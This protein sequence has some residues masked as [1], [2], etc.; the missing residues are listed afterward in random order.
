MTSAAAAPYSLRQRMM[1]LVLGVLAVVWLGA[2]AMTWWEVR[3]ELD[4]LLDAHLTQAASLLVAQYKPHG[5]GDDDE[6]DGSDAPALHRYAPRVSFQVYSA[7]VLELSS[8][9]APHQRMVQSPTPSTPLTEGFYSAE[10]DDKTWR[11]FFTRGTHKDMEIYV[12][13]EA[14]SR[15][16]ILWAILRS[17]LLPMAIALPLL[18]LM[19]WGVIYRSMTPIE[20]LRS[21]LVLRRSD[22]LEPIDAG[23]TPQE[24]TP[25]VAALNDLFLRIG[26]LLESE[27]R[28]TADASHEL[29]TPIAAI[30]AQAQVALAATDTAERR[31]ALLNTL[32]GCDRASHLVEQLLTLSRLDA[33]SAPELSEVEICA[34]LRQNVADLAPKWLDKD[35]NVELVAPRSCVIRA[36][37]ALF[38][39][40]V[41]N[42]LDNAVRY[43]PRSAQILISVY[44]EQETFQLVVEDSGPGM[45][46][47]DL[48]RLGERFFRVN[49]HVETGSGLGWSIVRRI[50]SVHRLDVVLSRSE[51]LGGLCASVSGKK[52]I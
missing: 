44:Q 17:T 16:S 13:E 27:R 11:V 28:F 41:R 21:A 19:L 1:A 31:T 12:G 36:N 49:G 15:T 38:G 5:D 32:A 22:A 7:G 3:H 39:I 37:S 35:Q 26:G 4:E 45:R 46:E 42:L 6:D 29:R 52:S 33:A 51:K 40:L 20:R 48:A 14:A 47:A 9:N 25:M 10:F 30:R 43:S 2:A 23:N 18:A 50:A 8:A 24:I 34:L